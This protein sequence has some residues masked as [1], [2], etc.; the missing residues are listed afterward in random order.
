M[1]T[2]IK[3]PKEISTLEKYFEWVKSFTNEKQDL[4]VWMKRRTSYYPFD[5]RNE[6]DNRV[7]YLISDGISRGCS[8]IKNFNKIFKF[9]IRTV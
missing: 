1:I 3:M 5:F 4:E 2:E 6:D 8:N 7:S 9:Q